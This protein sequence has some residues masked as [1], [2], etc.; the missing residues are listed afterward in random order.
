MTKRISFFTL[1]ILMLLTGI[2]ASASLYDC[3][4]VFSQNSLFGQAS[5][6]IITPSPTSTPTKKADLDISM[7]FRTRSQIKKNLIVISLILGGFLLGLIIEV[8]F[9]SKINEVLEKASWEGF[10]VIAS[11]FKGV[12]T[13]LFTMSGIYLSILYVDIQETELEIMHKLIAIVTII[14]LTIVFSKIAVALISQYM[15]K[16]SEV[17][18]HTTLVGNITRLFIYL[19]GFLILLN[20]L[21]ISITPL[22][23]A[24]GVGGLAVALALQ[25][26]LSNLFSGLY[27]IATKEIKPGNYIKIGTGEEGYITDI[28]WRSTMI[29]TLKDHMIVIPNSKLAS[30]ILSNYSRPHE[31]ISIYV[32][33]GVGYE[34]DLSQV[35]EV[36]KEVARQVLQG[37]KGG[38]KDFEPIIRFHTF[39]DSSINLTVVLRVQEF[40]DQYGIRHEFIKRLHVRY[41]KEGINIPFPIRT[42]QMQG[43]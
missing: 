17:V 42:V 9:K 40:S 39:A 21:G 13:F 19:M 1:I 31:D 8:V 43:D 16:V 27:I 15:R 35:E 2:A 14:F 34:S 4:S 37:V 32:Q 36:T 10:K 23:T 7:F 20:T 6:P 38:V 33:V 29:R 22:L 3:V 18:P 25:D 28:N 24:F 11:S 30:A 26:T 5:T 12:I 41:K